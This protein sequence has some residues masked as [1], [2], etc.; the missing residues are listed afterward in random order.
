MVSFFFYWPVDIIAHNI[1]SGLYAALGV[2][3]GGNL[4]VDGA[5][6]LEFLPM[7]SGNLLT[8]LSIWWP[9]GQLVA[10]LIAWA[11]IPNFSC[12]SELLSCNISAEPCCHKEDNMGWRYFVITLGGITF[13]MFICR[14]FVFHLF[15]SPKFL[16][17]R[18]RQA[19][20][21]AVVHGIAH[22]NKRTTWLTEEILNAIGGDPLVVK[23]TKL[24][25]LEILKR[26]MNKFSA[27]QIAPIFSTRKLGLNSKLIRR[28]FP[29]HLLTLRTSCPSLVLLGNNR[30]GLPAIQR[31]PTSIPPERR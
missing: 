20:A 12:D 27:Q 26:Q 25:N 13:L 18:G 4:P 16:L 2:G 15:E 11:L 9:I 24:S 1:F 28:K 17:S 10:S 3:V 8:L 7:A 29:I 31:L 14:F 23:Q 19:E 21:V 22:H 5:L 6:F 30:N